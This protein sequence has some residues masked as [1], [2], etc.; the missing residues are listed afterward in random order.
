MKLTNL[1]TVIIAAVVLLVP[2]TTFATAQQPDVLIIEGKS[3]SLYAN[4]LED[5]F[6]TE[7]SRPRFQV[8]P[9]TMSS[10]NWRGYVA[11]W[12]IENKTLVLIKI[13]SWFCNGGD[14]DGCRKVELKDLFREQLVDG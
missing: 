10:G 11:T 4:P 6:K 1:Q 5:F 7:K 14:K 9:N 12:T 8:E 2:V 3:Y 13:D